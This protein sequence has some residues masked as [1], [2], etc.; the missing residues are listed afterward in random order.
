MKAP[1]VSVLMTAYNRAAYID[2][3]IGSVLTQTFG[4]FELIVVDDGSSDDTVARA[5]AWAA[6]D[7]RVRVVVNSRNRGD[8]ANRNHAASFA[9]GHYVKYHDS[10]DVMY[11]HCLETMVKALESAPEAGF[12]LTR[13]Q[14]WQGGPCPMLLTPRMSYQREFLGSGMFRGGPAC[15]LFRAH[16]LR[17]LGGFE[18]IGAPSDLIFW[19]RS[20]ARVPV[21]LVPADLF[22]YR[23]HPG[24]QLLRRDVTIQY[25]RVNARI[26]QAL[27]ADEC[28][29]D[30]A[31]LET[32]RRNHV[33]KVA[34]GALAELLGGR[35]S[36]GWA[37][38]RFAGLSV[39][40]WARYLR[41][42]RRTAMAGT[43]TT[44]NGEYVVR[45]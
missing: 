35:W 11:P 18:D 1:A 37:Q 43:P 23:V 20:C 26:W 44:A 29:L 41:V 12:A 42:P 36:V 22:W 2:A 16:V 21:V 7:Q 27:N 3:A 4:D 39:G 33:F 19:M 15:A 31:E 40:D 34:R 30:S 17:D 25:A 9:R 8:Y 45:P 32:A 10:D 24:Q 5:Q 13:S 14:A 28:P 6:M 38:V